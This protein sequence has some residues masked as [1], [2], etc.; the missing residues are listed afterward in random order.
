MITLIL[1]L[2]FISFAALTYSLLPILTRG[3][4]DINQ[5]QAQQVLN[6]ADLYLQDADLQKAQRITLVM[7][8]VLAIC[9]FLFFPENL[10][11]PGA[12]IGVI[13]GIIIPRIYVSS[14]ISK[15]KEKFNDQL[16]DALMIMSSS[17]RGGLSLVQAIEAVVDEMPDPVKRE[18][19]IVLGENKMGVSLEESLTRL[20]VRMPSVALQ[21][22]ITA[23]LLARETGGN[24]PVI[25]SRIVST[26]RE[27]KKIEQ[28]LK[29]LTIQGKIQAVVMTLL[30]L[31][32]VM[33][34][35][36][37]NP[38]FFDVMFRLP[39]GRQ[40]LMVCVVLWVVGAILIW[41]ISKFKEV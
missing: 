7:P 35:S 9:G 31:F 41:R 39:E 22:M 16:V 12:I 19:G 10:R 3:A 30:P 38:K 32:F 28:N 37:T 17:F 13:V 18:F 24:L 20:Q 5:R 15:R 25:F 26:I 33:G 34:V 23:I 21:Q 27:R 6:N 40:M 14:L 8:A 4:T 36:A 2:I 29:T 11:V 1:F